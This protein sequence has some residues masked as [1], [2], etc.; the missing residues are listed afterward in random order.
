MLSNLKLKA[1]LT[2]LGITP[3]PLFVRSDQENNIT[4]GIQNEEGVDPIE[5]SEEVSKA[6]FREK[7]KSM[8]RKTKDG[9]YQCLHCTYNNSRK[10]VMRHVESHI[11]V[12]RVNCDLCLRSFKNPSSLNSHKNIS[13][14]VIKKNKRRL[15]N[16]K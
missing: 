7:V 16:K 12:V 10:R 14:N 3:S 4:E 11:P 13:H 8:M 6:Q 15:M 9:I 1:P 2:N 5:H